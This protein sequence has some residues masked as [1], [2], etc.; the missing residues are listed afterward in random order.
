V[1]ELAALTCGAAKRC[2]T[3]G[4]GY[5]DL[6][7]YEETG[8]RF[9]NQTESA[10]AIAGASSIPTA[11]TATLIV[12]RIVAFPPRPPTPIRSSKACAA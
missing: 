10:F 12:A 4:R 5:G 3:A 11:A 1:T 9:P 8:E 6:S 2:I 7:V